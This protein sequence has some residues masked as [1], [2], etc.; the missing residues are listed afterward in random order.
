M[1]CWPSVSVGS[2]STGSTNP[3]WEKISECFKTQNLNLP[4]AGNY[5][6]IICVILS[7]ISHLEMI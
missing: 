7:M 5:L 2:A 6:Q 1:Y 3:G 4:R